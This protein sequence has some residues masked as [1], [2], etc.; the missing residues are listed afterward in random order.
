LKVSSLTSFFESISNKNANK[1]VQIKSV[2]N[3]HVSFM[4]EIRDNLNYSNVNPSRQKDVGVKLKLSAQAREDRRAFKAQLEK[5]LQQG[6][7]KPNKIESLNT[8]LENNVNKQQQ[9]SVPIVKATS[10]LIPCPP[11]L[12]SKPLLPQ[13]RQWDKI[14]G[15]ALD[16]ENKEKAKNACSN[17][18]SAATYVAKQNNNI[19]LAN[20]M[21]ELNEILRSRELH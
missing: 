21:S 16:K 10:G 17:K 11:P 13:A 19:G 3:V 14:D 6:P 18:V 15:G 20:M 1:T 2:R 4:K 9:S 5:K 8:A 7:V 12:P